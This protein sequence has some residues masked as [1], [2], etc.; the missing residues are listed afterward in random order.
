MPASS[1]PFAR[2]FSVALTIAAGRAIGRAR[3]V[4]MTDAEPVGVRGHDLDVE[5][6][7]AEL[8]GDE[9]CVLRLLPVGL[10]RQ[11]QHHLSRRMH[12]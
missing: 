9:L 10:G 2:I 6:G 8:A 7:D 3:V 5:R 1:C 11:A 12:A 4:A